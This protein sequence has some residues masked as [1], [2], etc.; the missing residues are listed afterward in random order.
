MKKIDL[1]VIGFVGG[2]RRWLNFPNMKYNTIATTI[3]LRFIE[4]LVQSASPSLLWKR[5]KLNHG[6]LSSAASYRI[7]RLSA[8]WYLINSLCNWSTW[9]SNSSLSTLNNTSLNKRSIYYLSIHFRALLFQGILIHIFSFYH[10]MRREQE[11]CLLKAF[12]FPSKS[13]RYLHFIS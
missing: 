2:E 7:K 12:R 4:T 1:V 11:I 5:W 10:N 13:V 6:A 9:I 8:I 3:P